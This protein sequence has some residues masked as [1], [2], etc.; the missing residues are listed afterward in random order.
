MRTIHLDY[1]SRGYEHM[2]SHAIQATLQN[3]VTNPPVIK[4]GRKQKQI[5]KEEVEKETMTPETQNTAIVQ[6]TV[7]DLTAFN[8]VLLKKEVTLP[9]R[10]KNIEECMTAIEND[11]EKFIS[12]FYEGLV[13]DAKSKARENMSGFKTVDDDGNLGE[14]Y[15]GN[16]ADEKKG[17]LINAAVLSL[18]KMQ[19]Y[20]KELPKEK[21]AELKDK[22]REFLRSN[23]AMLASIQG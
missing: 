4:R 5:I 15:S 2:S 16:Y 17:E 18:A 9:A 11:T 21:K 22:A 23:P 10:P 8:D 19:G 14:E 1:E 20:S 7:F 12:I 6:K 3:E 13:E